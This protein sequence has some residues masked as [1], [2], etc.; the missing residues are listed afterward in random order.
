MT[1][2]DLGR[3]ALFAGALLAATACTESESGPIP[4]SAIGAPPQLV[5]PNLQ[6]ID[7]ASAFLLQAAA[8]G[9]VR[10][11]QSGQ[12]EPALAQSW[13]VSNDG[14]RYTFRLAR[15]RWSNGEP[16]KAEQVV[17]RLR[18]AASRA[19]RN[20]LKPLLGAIA[21]V[22]AMTDDVLEISLV[23]PRPNFLQLL[24]QPEMAVMRKGRGSGPFQVETRADGSH[25]LSAHDPDLEEGEEDPH[26]PPIML[27]GERAGLAVARFRAGDADFVTGG[28]VGDLAVA[29]AAD[30]PAAALRFD[31]VAGM[32]GLAF[33]AAAGPWAEP[34]ARSALS[35]SIDRPALVAALGVPT[36]QA[37][38]SVLPPGIE[39]LPNPALP[40]WAADPL[41]VRR[42]AAAGRVAAATGEGRPSVRVALPEGPGYRLL[43]AHLR[44]DW[45]AIGVEAV[46]ARA[47][48]AADL[49]LIDEVAPAALSTWYLRHF[50]CDVSRVCSQEADV[51]LAA[52]R[53]APAIGERQNAL[54]AA[55]RLIADAVPF[56]PLAAPVRWSLVSPRLT[57]FQPNP[58][59]SRFPG[60]LV[61]PA[62]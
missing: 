42:A 1:I 5:N 59:G 45:S 40:P 53:A 7:A 21:E 62:R 43:F 56:I 20:P 17:E 48:E 37:R 49:R 54:R 30:L 15:T 11:D 2:Q 12:I 34:D 16:V 58:F 4:V 19:S 57:G 27:R 44:R 25:L 18:A 10:F 14:L 26:G 22:E 6:P 3:R 55:D 47:G 9:L 23:S 24:A 28:R 51:L 39:E 31:P 33:T 38:E 35:M 32:F 36:L 8:Q 41:P 13:I 50:T 46:R 61:A 29:R 52:A 60:S